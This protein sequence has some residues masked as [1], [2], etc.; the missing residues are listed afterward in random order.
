MSMQRSAKVS[1][2][3]SAAVI[4]GLAVLAAPAVSLFAGAGGPVGDR[5][6]GSTASAE[7]NT[8]VAAEASSPPSPGPTPKDPLQAAAWEIGCDDFAKVGHYASAPKPSPRPDKG[9]REFANGTATFGAD[10]GVETYT[11]AAGDAG[12]AIGERFCVDWVTVF[13]A[14]GKWAPADTIQPGDVIQI[15]P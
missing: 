7:P 14:N 8:E 9:A 4:V 12:I 11:V 10:G 1:M 6:E 3:V 15:N 5:T 13:V 2:A